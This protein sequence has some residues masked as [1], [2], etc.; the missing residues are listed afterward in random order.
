MSRNHATQILFTG[1]LQNMAAS[2]VTRWLKVNGAR[3]FHVLLTNVVG[4]SSPTGTWSFE[5]TEDTT[6]YMESDQP[7]PSPVAFAPLTIPA[8]GIHGTGLAVAGTNSTLVILADCPTWVRIRY[9]RSSG[10]DAATLAR[11]FGAHTEG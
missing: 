6:L 2:R 11:I 3:T 1:T 4:G 8:A 10:G 7:T 9:T 5:G